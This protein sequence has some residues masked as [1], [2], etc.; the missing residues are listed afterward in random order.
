MPVSPSSCSYSMSVHAA[1]ISRSQFGQCP[2][3]AGLSVIR[4]EGGACDSPSIQE[5][6]FSYVKHSAGM[7][8]M[9]RRG[10]A[11]GRV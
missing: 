7:Y 4:G 10:L 1:V 6:Y 2:T 8:G 3:G 11:F 9:Y 5:F